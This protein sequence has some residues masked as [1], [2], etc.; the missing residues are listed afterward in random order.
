[1]KRNRNVVREQH[2]KNRG[3]KKSK[4]AEKLAGGKQ[5][6]GGKGPDSCCANTV[7]SKQFNPEG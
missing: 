1:V 7:R 2:L 6:Y 4:Y 3:S 5:M